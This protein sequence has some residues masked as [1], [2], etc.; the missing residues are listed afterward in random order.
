MYKREDEAKLNKGAEL[1]EVSPRIA[2]YTMNI[3]SKLKPQ[4]LT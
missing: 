3:E 1:T 4:I 2:G